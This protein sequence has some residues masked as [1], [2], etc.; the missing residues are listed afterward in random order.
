M[1]RL[2][3]PIVAGAINGTVPP[4][5]ASWELPRTSADRAV[6]TLADDTAVD[7]ALP[8]DFPFQGTTFANAQVH[9]NGFVSFNNVTAE[10]QNKCLGNQDAIDD[11]IYGW[12]ADLDP[13]V[14]NGQVS[15]FESGTDRFVVEFANIT[16]AAKAADRYTVNFQIVLYRN[17]DIALNYGQV[18]ERQALPPLVTVGIEARDG[19]FYNQIACK[20]GQTELG[21]LPTSYQRIMLQAEGSLY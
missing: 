17:G 12:W 9:A 15:T 19:L 20:D 2:Y 8:F 11:A 16:S 6:L 18:P 5:N 3:F 10:T 21:F 7:V 4:V 13:T 14:A 1:P